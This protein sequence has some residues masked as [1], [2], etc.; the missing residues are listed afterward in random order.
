[1][2]SGFSCWWLEQTEA[3][4]HPGIANICPNVQPPASVG[5]HDGLVALDRGATEPVVEG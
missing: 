1:M 2:S 4:R 3:I 5:R